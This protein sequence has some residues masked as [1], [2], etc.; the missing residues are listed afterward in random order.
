MAGILCLAGCGKGAASKATTDPST[1]KDTGA[2]T[3]APSASSMPAAEDTLTLCMTGDILLHDEMND[4]ARQTDGSYN[5]D[6]LFKYLGKTIG[7]KDLAIVNQEVPIGGR[8]LGVTGYPSF[9]AP[10]EMADALAKAGFDVV[11]HAT[12]H[13]LDK[14]GRGVKNTLSNWKKN[15]PDIEVVGIHDSNEDQKKITVVEKK[16]IKVAILNYTYGTNGISLPSDMPYAVDLLE[17][18]RIRDDL[19]RAEELADFTIVCPHW[20]TEYRLET[21]EYQKKWTA[22]FRECGA[23]LV[24]GTHPHVIERIEEFRDGD[25]AHWTNNHGNGDMLVYYSLGNYVN[26]TNDFG[27]GIANRMVGGIAEVTLKR[28]A[29][30]QVTISDHDI[31][32]I[33][34]HVSHNPGEISVYPLSDYT[35]ELAAKNAI[36]QQDPAFSLEYCREL[37]KKI[38]R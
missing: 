14:V 18:K 1:V 7:S 32:P 29:D 27:E 35:R 23:D 38:W 15:H 31:L 22:L 12:N 11:C 6:Y 26:W 5:Y 36:R 24:L 3:T 17:E 34:C 33:V 9:N 25:K 8:E 19:A 16:G 10:Y 13:A 30:G 2:S 37:C 28:G 20:G 4:A 21:D